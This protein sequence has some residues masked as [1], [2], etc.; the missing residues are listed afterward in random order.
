VINGEAKLSS[1]LSVEDHLARFTHMFD[2][3]ERDRAI[4][5][6]SD[7]ASNVSNTRATSSSSR[8]VKGSAPPLHQ[9]SQSALASSSSVSSERIALAEPKSTEATT[10]RYD[11]GEKK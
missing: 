11:S 8:D 7:E 10:W 6:T 3:A 2:A 1:A 4:P 5:V 9:E